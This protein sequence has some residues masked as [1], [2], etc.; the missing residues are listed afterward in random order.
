MTKHNPPEEP[1]CAKSPAYSRTLEDAE[2]L[3]QYAAEVGTEVD[4]ATRAAVLRARTAC[5]GEWTEEIAASLLAALTTLTAQLKPVTPESAKGYFKYRSKGHPTLQ[6]YFWVTIGLAAVIVPVSVATFITS[7]IST[8]ITNDIT[9]ANALAVKLGAEKLSGSTSESVT[10]KH[11][12]STPEPAAPSTDS[13]K[14]RF[15]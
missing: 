13:G 7:A 9:S 2:R 6:F 12:D 4:D 8:N 1:N 15:E 5:T 14:I 3:L 10:A 11:S